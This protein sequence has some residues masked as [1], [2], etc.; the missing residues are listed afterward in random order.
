[1]LDD[2]NS[3]EIPFVGLVVRRKDLEKGS[4]AGSMNNNNKKNPGIYT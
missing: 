4:L 3:R 1:M 2:S